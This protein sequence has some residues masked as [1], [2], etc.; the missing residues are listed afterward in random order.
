[1]ERMENCL[2]SSPRRALGHLI[3]VI[4]QMGRDVLPSNNQVTSRQISGC[5]EQRASTDQAPPNVDTPNER[6]TPD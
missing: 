4:K 3:E 5:H 6:S 2:A 1:M